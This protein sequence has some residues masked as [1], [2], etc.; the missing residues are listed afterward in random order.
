MY[1]WD[2]LPVLKL[3]GKLHLHFTVL[4]RYYAF[5]A[6][7]TKKAL[8]YFWF[9]FLCKSR[10]ERFCI[11]YK[12]RGEKGWPPKL[13]IWPHKFTRERSCWPPPHPQLPSF[14]NSVI[15]SAVLLSNIF[16]VCEKQ[17]FQGKTFRQK[18]VFLSLQKQLNILRT[19]NN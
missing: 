15:S 18:G 9:H 4:T 2:S 17:E 13:C 7:L 12:L 11:M 10:N 5:K 16:W 6:N 3:G 8:K 19:C 14:I 1:N